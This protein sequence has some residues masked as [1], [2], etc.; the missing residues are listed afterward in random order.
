MC[1][2]FHF[3]RQTFAMQLLHKGFYIPSIAF[4]L[5][6]VFPGSSL[7]HLNCTKEHLEDIFAKQKGNLYS[8]AA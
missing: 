1:I 8:I 6:H 5:R 3:F 4:F 7:T 2:T